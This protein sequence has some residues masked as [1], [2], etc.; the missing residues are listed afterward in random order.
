[1]LSLKSLLYLIIPGLLLI[2]CTENRHGSSNAANDSSYIFTDSD[3]VT[4]ISKVHN[5]CQAKRAFTLNENQLVAISSSGEILVGQKNGQRDVL[6]MYF[7]INNEKGLTFSSKKHKFLFFSELEGSSS[8]VKS[9]F[10]NTNDHTYNIEIR[11][12]LSVFNKPLTAGRKIGFDFALSDN[13]NGFE[14]EKKIAWYANDSDIWLNPGLWGTLLLQKN[15]E[16][17]VQKDSAITSYYSVDIPVIDGKEDQCWA[18]APVITTNSVLV[19]NINNTPEHTDISGALK[20]VW[21]ENAIYFFVTVT[22]DRI[23]RESY[24]GRVFDYGWIE[25]EYGNVVWKLE[26]E[27]AK[28]AGGATKNVTADTILQLNKGRY[29]LCY[30]SDE[31]HAFN[32]WDNTPPSNDFYGISI[33]KVSN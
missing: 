11:V 27:H 16:A 30:Q 10:F 28:H 12:P 20:S 22:D 17:P 26:R 31:S 32:Q 24:T 14:Q 1:M 15:N 33:R 6:E 23:V 21:N 25:D 13:D 9:A 4:A 18:N 3:T 7:D 8:E 19:G 29:F 2:S 5:Y